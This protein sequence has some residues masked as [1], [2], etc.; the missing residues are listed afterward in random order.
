MLRA[1]IH[2]QQLSQCHVA[3]M[4]DIDALFVRL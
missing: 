2:T 4:G 1:V 3:H